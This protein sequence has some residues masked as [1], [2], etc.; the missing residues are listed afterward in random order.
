MTLEATG[1]TKFQFE[2]DGVLVEFQ[3]N[4]AGEVQQASVYKDRQRSI[5]IRT[6]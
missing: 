4:E 6:K 2:P 5:W 3:S 1:E